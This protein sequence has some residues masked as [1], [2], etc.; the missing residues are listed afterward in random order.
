[1]AA[2][3]DDLE[4]VRYRVVAMSIKVLAMLD[5]A[6]EAYAMTN[7]R[8]ARATLSLDDDVNDLEVKT[9]AAC[10]RALAK[11]HP[12]AGDLR[13]VAAVMKLVTDLERVGDVAVNV[14]ERTIELAEL[15]PGELPAKARTMAELSRAMLGGA[16]R[17]FFDDD[18][19]RAQAIIEQDLDLDDAYQETFATLVLAMQADGRRVAASMRHHAVAKALERVGDHAT[20]VAELVLLKAR[21]DDVR[22]TGA[23][24]LVSRPPPA[25]PW[26]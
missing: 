26:R 9:D 3:A 20:N 2:L 16:V 18:V 4:S 13:F 12:M 21:G 1:M 25:A 19:A 24:A 8:L 17:A 15:G 5:Q 22:H 11:W 6:I 10:L 23:S 7:A 14:C